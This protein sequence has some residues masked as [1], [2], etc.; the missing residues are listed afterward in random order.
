[1]SKE[2]IRMMTAAQPPGAAPLVGWRLWRLREGRLGSWAAEHVWQPGPNEAHCLND[3]I[4]AV[5]RRPPCERSP[6]SGWRGGI[7]AVLEPERC[8]RMA[9]EGAV[10][11]DA[12]TIVMGLMVGWGTTAIHGAEGFRCQHAAVTCL[13]LDAINDRALAAVG[14]TLWW[15]G[16]M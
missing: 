4:G 16:L 10:W 15:G 3:S 11:W 2:R 8:L 14:R 5:R 1:S 12:G 9:R 13:F 7:W 6:G